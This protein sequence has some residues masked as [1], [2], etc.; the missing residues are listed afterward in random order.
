[1][2]IRWMLRSAAGALP[3]AV[4]LALVACNAAKDALLDVSV[5]D[6]VT[7]ETAQSAAGAQSFYTAGVGEF[8]RFIGGDRAGSSP[9]G[10]NLTGG[11][12]ADELISARTGTEPLDSRSI[13]PNSFPVDTW[14]QVGNTQTR[15]IRAARLLAQFPP[16][17]GGAAQLALLHAM[18]G[19][20]YAITAEDYCNG[21]PMWDA[22]SEEHPQ[23]AT[24]ST[25]QLN[26]LA[27]AQ[28]DS[29]IALNGGAAT[30]NLALVGKAR[31]IVN[32]AKPAT[33]AAALAAAAT[34]VAAVPTNYVF[35]TTFATSSSGLNNGIYDWANA[36]RN[37]GAVNKEGGNGLDYVVAK[38]PRVL[39]DGTK[40]QAGQ[41]GTPVPTLNQYT[42][43]DANVTV[44]SGIEALLI[45]AESQLAAGNA[46]DFIITLNAARAT[47]A[48]LAATPLTD[49]GSPAGRVDLL[50]R[51]RGFWMYLTAHR[52][53]DLRRLVRQYSRGAETVFPSGAYFK[54]GAYGTDVALVPSQTETNN[55]DWKA[56][57]DKNP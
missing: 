18:L 8:S 53:G 46:A 4:V 15:L 39:I 57:T 51:E 2:T 6:I 50:F 33:L 31:V 37:F 14:I 38:D 48:V 9:L 11:L 35:T 1:M 41:D 47:N 40:I 26:A 12:L 29:A 54:G 30:N 56:C 20:T 36:T 42:K 24:Y 5:P 3:V 17:T 49:P 43:P 21:I 25:D 32:Q 7:T 10:L 27:L 45:K 52:L 34:L 44:A 19:Y 23:T 28:F 55:P 13:N 16:A 22:K